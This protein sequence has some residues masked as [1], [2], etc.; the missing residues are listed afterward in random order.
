MNRIFQE[1]K[2]L[3]GYLDNYVYWYLTFAVRHSS[4]TLLFHFI[5]LVTLNFCTSLF[6]RDSCFAFIS[7]TTE[8]TTANCVEFSRGHVGWWPIPWFPPK[9]T[10]VI[11]QSHHKFLE[12]YVANHSASRQRLRGLKFE[13]GNVTFF[14]SFLRN[15][16]LTGVD[17]FSGSH[18]APREGIGVTWSRLFWDLLL[19]PMGT[20]IIFLI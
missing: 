13:F 14:P 2:N 3:M 7:N 19:V 16:P 10:F 11:G 18:K 4:L 1:W 20:L 6:T 17:K 8:N 9:N 5:K 15:P 12:F